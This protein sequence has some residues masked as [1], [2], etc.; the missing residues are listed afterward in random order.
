MGV[1]VGPGGEEG[2]VGRHQRQAA[3]IGEVQKL[4]LNL[5]F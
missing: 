3:L 1:M 2:L 5:F 4:R